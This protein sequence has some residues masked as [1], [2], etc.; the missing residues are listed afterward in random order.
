MGRVRVGVEVL[1]IIVVVII[2]A[3]TMFA[4]ASDNLQHELQRRSLES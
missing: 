2:A 1:I 4:M 3:I